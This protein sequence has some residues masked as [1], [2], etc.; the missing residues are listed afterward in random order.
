MD[1]FPVAIQSSVVFVKPL[2][3]ETFSPAIYIRNGYA[4]FENETIEA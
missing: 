2:Y 1:F 4:H 3:D